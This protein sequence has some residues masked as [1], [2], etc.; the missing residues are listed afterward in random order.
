MTFRTRLIGISICLALL[1]LMTWGKP[2][3]LAFIESNSPIIGICKC[4]LLGCAF[5][6]CG[7]LLA[8]WGLKQLYGAITQ[9]KIQCPSCIGTGHGPSRMI[10]YNAEGQHISNWN[11]HLVD[12]RVWTTD[13]ITCDGVGALPTG[14]FKQGSSVQVWAASLLWSG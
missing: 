12:K 1:A 4:I 6:V 2:L 7:L 11:D 9:T 10:C 8:R 5:V 14:F 13:C 3:T